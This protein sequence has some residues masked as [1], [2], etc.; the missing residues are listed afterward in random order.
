MLVEVDPFG[1]RVEEE[2][3]GRGWW[4]DTS[5]VGSWTSLPQMSFRGLNWGFSILPWPVGERIDLKLLFL[6]GYGEYWGD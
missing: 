2:G 5:K 1:E 4:V 6:G 3:E